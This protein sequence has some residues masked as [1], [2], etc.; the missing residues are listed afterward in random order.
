MKPVEKGQEVLI[1][2]GENLEEQVIGERFA[3]YIV[4]EQ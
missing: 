4:Q 1:V 3:P 2:I